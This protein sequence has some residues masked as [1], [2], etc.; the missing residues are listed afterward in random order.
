MATRPEWL[1]QAPS[2]ANVTEFFG[3][4]WLT[5]ACAD[6]SLYR[7]RRI[8]WRHLLALAVFQNHEPRTYRH[9]TMAYVLG[10]REALLSSSPIRT[11]YCCRSLRVSHRLPDRADFWCGQNFGG[12][13]ADIFLWLDTGEASEFSYG[14]IARS[15]GRKLFW[16]EPTRATSE[17]DCKVSGGTP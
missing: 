6:G 15:F 10:D 3:S 14:L 4:P 5:D 17:G 7:L 11:N 1:G 16:L 12:H 8:L 13:R 2:S 9:L